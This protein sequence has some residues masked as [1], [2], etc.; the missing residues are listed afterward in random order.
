MANQNYLELNKR[1]RVFV[2]E[3]L[4]KRPSERDFDYQCYCAEVAGYRG[5]Q[6][7]SNRSLK[8][9]DKHPMESVIKRLMGNPRVLAALEGFK[10]EELIGDEFGPD[11]IKRQLIRIAQANMLDFAK[12]SE[13]GEVK[14]IDSAKLTRAQGECIISVS[15]TV[16]KYGGS[17]KIER[18]NPLDALDKLS[19]IHGMYKDSLEI[20]DPVEKELRE[21]SDEEI[22]DGIRSILAQR[23][24]L[25]DALRRA[26]A[27][28]LGTGAGEAKKV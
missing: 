21:M 1:Q 10:M 16:T 6:K 19:R 8:Y 28:G 9:K 4:K 25:A 24:D 13:D 7:N 18:I 20:T 11:H 26:V 14:F 27:D 2:R 17:I 22:R 5:R 23:P 12:W 15:Q 3:M